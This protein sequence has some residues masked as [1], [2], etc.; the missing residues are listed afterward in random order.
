M[1]QLLLRVWELP[2]PSSMRRAVEPVVRLRW[3]QRILVPHFLVGVVGL[4]ENERGELL[5]LRHT[6]R[7][8]Y[9]WGLPTGFL[10]HGEQPSDAL[11]REIEEEVGFQVDLSSVRDVYVD[12]ERH[13]V[14]I[15]YTG[16]YRGGAFVS[17]SEVSEARFFPLDQLPSLLPDQARLVRAHLR[18]EVPH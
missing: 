13:L 11:K 9:P 14:N 3:L 10:E 1:R 8:E 6:Y 4:I 16:K 17:S 7:Q 18:M 15:I 5:V 12:E 2:W